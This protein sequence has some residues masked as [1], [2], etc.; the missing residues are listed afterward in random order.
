MLERS[1]LGLEVEILILVA[2]Q[3]NM[4]VRS[5]VETYFTN[6][7]VP[8]LYHAKKIQPK[9]VFLERQIHIMSK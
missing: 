3:Y 5:L 6:I 1:I 4:F 2:Y 7:E 8:H 9:E